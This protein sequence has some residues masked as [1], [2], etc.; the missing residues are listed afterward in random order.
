VRFVNAA[1]R[2]KRRF[3]YEQVLSLLEN[4][5]GP[6]SGAMAVE[7][8]ILELLW[9]MRDLAVILN[10]RRLKRGSLQLSM[11]EPELEY[12]KEG[13]VVGAHFRKH[14]ISHQMIEEFMLLAN[15]AVADHLDQ[16]D[17]A[18]LRRIHPAP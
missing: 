18:F 4:P 2:V 15:E 17:I 13:R 7:P 11:P 6:I 5:N 1:I 16:K 14:D 3:T 12:D 10:K 9:R 8:E